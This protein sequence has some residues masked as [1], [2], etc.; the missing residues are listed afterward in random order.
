MR[1]QG[2]YTYDEKTEEKI[3][4]FVDFTPTSTRQITFKLRQQL[5]AKISQP[6]VLRLLESLA[7][8]GEIR[9]LEIGLKHKMKCWSR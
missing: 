8:K 3:L 9:C 2:A 5:I 7:K 4:D 6:T 1:T